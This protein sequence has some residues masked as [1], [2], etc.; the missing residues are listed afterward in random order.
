M[1]SQVSVNLFTVGRYLCYQVY[2][3]GVAISGTRFL[4]GGGS[5]YIQ[6]IGIGG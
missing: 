4:H 3:G 6:G 1:F 5:R 2:S